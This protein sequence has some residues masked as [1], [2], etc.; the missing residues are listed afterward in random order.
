MTRWVRQ[1]GITL[2]GAAVL[3]GLGALQTCWGSE[4]KMSLEKKNLGVTAD[5]KQV[6][7]YTLTNVNGLK[8]KVMTYGAIDHR[9]RDARP[10]RQAGQHHACPWIRWPTTWPAIP[11]S[12]RSPA[13]TPTASPRASSRSTAR[14]T[15]GHQQRPEPPP[16]R[17]EG[18]R[19]GRLEGRA[20]PAANDWWA[21]TLHATSAPTATR[22]TPATL[23]AKVIYTLT[24]DNELKMDYTATT[25]K[26]TVVNLTNHAYWNLAAAGSG[27]VLGHELMLNADRYLPVDD[28]LIPLGEPSRVKGT[29][30]DFTTAHDDRLADRPGRRAATT[31]ATCSTRRAGRDCRWPP[32]SS[33]P[34]AAG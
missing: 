9:G 29:P 30:M 27:D 4:K 16:R 19:Q 10:Q 24:D 17:H 34:R 22:A 5:G 11:S 12:A 20:G 18:L 26:P 8:V 32:R 25:D 3:A 15:P 33:S 21:S 31:T 28:T 13:A 14:S 2:A 1:L 7:E 23:T 6:D